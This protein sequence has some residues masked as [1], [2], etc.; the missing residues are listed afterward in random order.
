MVKIDVFLTALGLYLC[1]VKHNEPQ[2]MLKTLNISKKLILSAAFCAAL[3]GHANTVDKDVIKTALTINNVKAG[4]LLSIKDTNGIT[5]YKEYIE[6]TGTYKKGFDL[7]ALPNGNYFFEVNKDFEI[8]TIPFTV[9]NNQVVFNKEKEVT[10][11]KPYIREISDKLY[12]SKLAPNYASLN[13]DIYANYDGV[14]QL[15]HNDKIENTQTIEK[16][17][18]LEKG[19]YKIILTSDNKEYTKFINN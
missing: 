14:F 18:Q 16:V 13:I 7:T 9:N 2:I 6:A 5:L 4:N 8:K 10:I 3:A 11:F 19:N 15:I 17:Y 12:I 1:S